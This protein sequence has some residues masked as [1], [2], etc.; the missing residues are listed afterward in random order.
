MARDITGRLIL[1]GTL[2]ARTPLHVGGLGEDVDTDLPLARNGA[3]QLY[4]P[5]TS[6]A[7]ALRQWCEQSF[8]EALV[9][10]IWGFQK[11]DRG[12]A[13]HVYLE[14]S[15]VEHPDN[16]AVEIRDGVGIDR[17]TGAA[18]EHIKY[19]RAVLPRG[20]RL[21]LRLTVELGMTGD[22]QGAIAM[23]AALRDA[24]AAGDVRLGA[25]KTRGLGR[26]ELEPG[27][28]LSEQVVNS[29]EG[30]LAALKSPDRGDPI[31]QKV[32][33]PAR[34]SP[35]LVFTLDW[36]PVGPLMVKAGFDGIAVDMLPL[37][38]RV[39]GE[40]ALV[41]PGSS[42]KGALRSQAERIVRTL[43]DRTTTY[44]ADPKKKFLF[45]VDLP[46]INELFG[47]RGLSASDRRA[48]TP[49]GTNG[50]IPGLGALAIDD[51]YATQR[52]TAAAWQK[53]FSAEND[54]QVST[55]LREANAAAWQEAYHVAV[56]RW[57][58]GAA[59]SFLYT[60]LEPHGVA[61]EPLRLTI[62][63]DRLTE[64]HQ[65]PSVVL[66]LLLLRDLGRGRLPLGFAT[67]RGM[68]AVALTEVAVARK[69]ARGPLNHLDGVILE[70][71]R[72]TP[73]LTE[74]LPEL[75]QAWREWIDS[76]RREGG[77]A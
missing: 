68:G 6:I 23:F 34:P 9:R 4:A 53:V 69:V 18:A 57:T 40:L 28:T 17:D 14:D 45:D 27:A 51:C 7:G 15:V 76:A 11:D 52:M 70:N 46:L 1:S 8:G 38:S 59:E 47:L 24:L 16:V 33:S 22:R 35:R 54:A 50:P 73:G 10:T 77:P 20:T 44:E 75:N 3:G 26:V 60:V 37:M 48:R 30:I 74:K 13:S 21:P 36:R 56:D 12:E 2:V 61:W 67:H 25:A 31:P 5:G 29:R 58:G 43:L 71:G 62:D 32:P 63:L 41:L 72:F 39:D 66:V 49:A 42:S 19:D 65:L 55:A 64:T